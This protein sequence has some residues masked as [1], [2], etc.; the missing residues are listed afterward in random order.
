MGSWGRTSWQHWIYLRQ[1]SNRAKAYTENHVAIESI[2]NRACSKIASNNLANVNLLPEKPL[3]LWGNGGILKLLN[4]IQA[5]NMPDLFQHDEA[6]ETESSVNDIHPE[7]QGLRNESS[8]GNEAGRTLWPCK[9]GSAKG[10][11]DMAPDF[12]APL[13]EFKQYME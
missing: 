11:I 1:P 12:D 7:W 13:E 10:K 3:G 9:A 8:S 4:E 6:L 5:T 2:N